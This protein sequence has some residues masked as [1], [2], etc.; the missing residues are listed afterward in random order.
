M[1]KPI[2]IEF[3]NKGNEKNNVET[4]IDKEGGW[5]Y[6]RVDLDSTK[7]PT[8]NNSGKSMMAKGFFNFSHNDQRIFGN[9]KKKLT[10]IKLPNTNWH[11]IKQETSSKK[12]EL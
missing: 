9:L 11:V 12:V 2:T 5:F 1:G 7:L 8:S 6:A 4:F 10:K 3:T